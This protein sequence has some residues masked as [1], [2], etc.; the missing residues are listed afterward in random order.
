MPRGRPKKV[1]EENKMSQE[2][3]LLPVKLIARSI[4]T[5]GATNEGQVLSIELEAYISDYLK[6]GYKLKQAIY[7]GSA[8]NRLDVLFVLVLPEYAV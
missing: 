1:Q 6:A 5:T 3:E 4:S 7:T 2:L 8:P